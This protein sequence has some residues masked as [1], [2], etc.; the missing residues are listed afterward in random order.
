MVTLMGTETRIMVSCSKQGTEHNMVHIP[1]TRRRKH[2]HGVLLDFWH[3]PA[4]LAI[5][6]LRGILDAI[7]TSTYENTQSGF[8]H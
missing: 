7:I 8:A 4:T 6:L 1:M 2:D 5:I 3:A